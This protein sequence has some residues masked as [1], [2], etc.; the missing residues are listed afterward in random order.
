M[1]TIIVAALAL[2]VLIVLIAI[3]SGKMNRFSKGSEDAQSSATGS[4]CRKMQD[5]GNIGSCCDEGGI[6]ASWIDCGEGKQCCY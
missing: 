3:L 1:T 2:I 4:V 5:T 6:S